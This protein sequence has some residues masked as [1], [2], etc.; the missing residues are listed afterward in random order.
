MRVLFGYKVEKGRIVPNEETA[1]VVRRLF[2]LYL[3]GK[4]IEPAAREAGLTTRG[5][6]RAGMILSDARYAGEGGLYPPLITRDTFDAAQRE[7]ARRAQYLGR[8]NLPGKGKWLEP[9]RP[10]VSFRWK[11]PGATRKNA[12]PQIKTCSSLAEAAAQAQSLYHMIK[13]K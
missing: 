9:I 5:H 12:V 7:R 6:K 4:G 3:S 2:E 10:A 8:D 11:V 13:R 1:P